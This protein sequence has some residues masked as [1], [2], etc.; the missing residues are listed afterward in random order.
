MHRIAQATKTMQEISW[1]SKMKSL[2][3]T[4]KRFPDM[5]NPSTCRKAIRAIQLP[6]EDRAFSLL[7]SRLDSFQWTRVRIFERIRLF[8]F[9]LAHSLLKRSVYRLFPCTSERERERRE[10]REKRRVFF[11]REGGRDDGSERKGRERGREGDCCEWLFIFTL[12]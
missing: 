12:S 6:T 5:A 1:H 4:A 9:V 3:L 8:L 2:T 10:K 11:R 7:S